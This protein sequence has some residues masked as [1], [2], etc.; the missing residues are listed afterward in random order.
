[1]LADEKPFHIVAAAAV[2]L[3]VVGFLNSAIF[4]LARAY[5]A[6]QKT[7]ISLQAN[8]E[9]YE[10]AVHVDYKYIDDPKYYDNFAWAVEEYSTQLEKARNFLIDFA[11]CT[12]SIVLLGTVIGNARPVD[13]IGRSCADASARRC[14]QTSEFHFHQ[15]Q[16]GLRTA[17]Q[18][19]GLFPQA[20]LF[21][22]VRS[23][24]EVHNARRNCGSVIR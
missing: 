24:Y 20:F 1:M 11:Q 14:Q 2:T 9:I 3:T 6:K 4:K 12:L 8:R 19:A 16:G 5:F 13:I 15:V 22:R 21:E 23:R 17:R 10:K 7:S 18:A